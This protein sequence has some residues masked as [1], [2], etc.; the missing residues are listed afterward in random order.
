MKANN[1]G[2]SVKVYLQHLKSG[3]SKSWPMLMATLVNPN[4][5]L[6][7]CWTTLRPF[8]SGGT[9]VHAYV[10]CFIL[11]DTGLA[12]QAGSWSAEAIS[13]G[14][15]IGIFSKY[16]MRLIFQF[17]SLWRI[18]ILPVSFGPIWHMPAHYRISYMIHTWF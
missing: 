4:P 6:A 11:I 3:F 18:L 7:A 10:Q 14:R 5:R 12:D 13:P 2:E 16:T 17:L 15:S 9:R 8:A 1:F